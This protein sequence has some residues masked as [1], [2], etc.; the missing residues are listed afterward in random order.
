VLAVDRPGLVG[1]GDALVSDVVGLGLVCLSA[2]CPLVL[3][4]EPNRRV[5][6][7]AHASWRSTV[8]GVTGRTVRLLADRY[9]ADPGRMVACICPSAGPRRYEVGPEVREAMLSAMGPDAQDF[10]RRGAGDRWLCNLWA[11][12]IFQLAAAGVRLD[13]IHLAG[14]CTITRNDMFPSHRAEGDPAGRFLAVIA[15]TR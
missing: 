10:F 15:R 4:A 12:N 6:G 14:I 11:A 5:V 2:D 7:I 8:A 13:R 3:L 9:G 1:D